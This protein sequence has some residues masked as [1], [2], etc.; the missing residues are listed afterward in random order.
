MME[1]MAKPGRDWLHEN[2][3][4][5][6]AKAMWLQVLG[7][8]KPGVTRAKVQAEVDVLFRGIIENGYP[9]TL[10]PELRKQALDQRIVV[11]NARTGAFGGRDVFSR[12]LLVLLAVAGLVL[13]IACANVSNMMLARATARSKSWHSAFIGASRTVDRQSTESPLL[14]AV[15]G[16]GRARG[17]RRVTMLAVL[18]SGRRLR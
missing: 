11:Q 13:L 17:R 12:Q 6:I 15:S 3:S 4:K 2:L 9:A 7:R 8:L 10:R 16:C 14:S 5:D 1:P 18:L